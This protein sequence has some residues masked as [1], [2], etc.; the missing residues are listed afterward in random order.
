[1]I[2][3]DLKEHILRN[4]IYNED[5]IFLN[6]MPEIT[7]NGKA[8]IGIV[9][10]GGYQNKDMLYYYDIDVYIRENSKEKGMEKANSLFDIFNDVL[11][12]DNDKC[13]MYSQ[14]KRLP[15][16]LILKNNLTEYYFSLTIRKERI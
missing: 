3:D 1:M 6:F 5:S 4:K 2:L 16:P 9:Q 14:V 12:V 13:S 10:A 8:C 7:Q 15:S 11:I